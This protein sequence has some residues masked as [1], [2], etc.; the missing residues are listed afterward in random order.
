[1]PPGPPLLFF[2]QGHSDTA[3][4]PAPGAAAILA[5]RDRLGGKG[6]SLH[7]LAALGFRVP[8]GFTIPVPWCEAYHA[9]G[10]L[11]AGL[12]DALAG[13]LG[14]LEDRTGKRLGAGLRLAVRSGAAES[15]PGMLDTVLGV[16]SPGLLESA[17]SR[18]FDSWRSERAEAYRREKGVTG[19]GG[20]AVTVQEMCPAEAAGVAFTVDPRTGTGSVLLVEA[21]RGL[22]ESL[23]SGAVTPDRVLLS[24]P[25]L[26]IEAMEPA[27]ERPA[28]DAETARAIA[29]EAVRVE[30]CFGFPVDVEWAVAGGE[31]HLLQARA[32]R[33]G[34]DRELAREVLLG[35][36]SRLV[37]G[38]DGAQRSAALFVRYNLDETLSHPTPMT[39]DLLRTL[40]RGPAGLLGLYRD[41]G[42]RPSK[43][44]LERG[45]LALVGG[46]LHAECGL[47][48]EVFFGSD[49]LGHDAEAVRRDPSLLDAPPSVW[50]SGGATPAKLLRV[51]RC[52]YAHRRRLERLRE[53]FL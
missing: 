15:M 23:V 31:V 19:L 26:E 16:D 27:G 24:R 14:R 20:T 46:R 21:V 8:A 13:A 49:I 48:A 9:E 36:A 40:F 41:L 12:H 2:H 53:N 22:G 18:V 43:R 30:E 47:A 34:R 17:V 10:R 5:G 32:I 39:W 50:A 6:A 29:C 42:F 38:L 1:M 33:A 3:P 7:A 25:G 44:V 37:D 11:P 35:D 4:G 28:I 51:L 45:F 52:S